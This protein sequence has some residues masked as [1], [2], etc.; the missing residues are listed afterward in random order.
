[1]TEL[2]TALLAAR[3][4]GVSATVLLAPG[5]LLLT[6]LRA[7]VEWTERV[8]LAFSLSYGWIFVLSIAVP[9]LGLNVDAAAV[10]TLGALAVLGIVAFKH[11]ARP[12]VARS[13]DRWD[14]LL[15]GLVLAAAVAA[16]IIEPSFTG[17]EALDLASISRFADGGA[18]SFSNTSLFPDTRPVYLFQPYQ[19]ALGVIG[20]WSGVDPLVALIKFRVILVPLALIFL[21]N[22]VRRLTDRRADAAAV[23]VV[24]LLFLGLDFPTWEMNSLFPLVRRGGVGAGLC[25]PAML[26]LCLAATRTVEDR[27][28]RRARQIA[29]CAAPV[30]L[31]ASLATHP[32]EMFTV[33][34]FA[35]GMTL[36]IATGLDRQ[37]DRRQAAMLLF[38]LIAAAGT[39][40]VLQTR[41]V[42]YVA[43]YEIDQKRPLRAELARLALNPIAA[44]AGQPLPAADLLT[45]TI[46]ATTAT[47]FGMIALPV[48][49]LRLPAT[50][51]MLAVGIVPLA[52][53]YATPAGF[54]LLTLLTSV[55]TVRD[56][57]AYFGLLGL[58][59]L[60]IALTAA[61]HAALDHAGRRP[62]GFRRVLTVAFGISLAASVVVLLGRPASRALAAAAIVRPVVVLTVGAA[63]ALATL[64]VAWRMRQPLVPASRFAVGV[65]VLTA[66]FAI[67]F[68]LPEAGLGGVFTRR[69]PIHVMRRIMT[70]R[71]A[72]SVLEWPAYYAQLQTT[73]APPL[74]VPRLVVDE[75]RRRIPPRQIVLADPRYSCALV[76]LIDAYCINPASIYGHYFQPAIA[77]FREYVQERGSD[78]PEHP[79]FNSTASLSDAERTL[80]Q[81]F[82]VQYVLTDPEFDDLMASK[83]TTVVDGITLET[84][85]GGYRLYRV[86]APAARAPAR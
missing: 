27:T 83:L 79:F 11:R 46:P 15:G 24:M 82:D 39:Y 81:R 84:D 62:A 20:R 56:V 2:E 73:I 66:C 19:L 86:T 75:L 22:L 33:L 32:L 28:S 16:W 64:V 48:A 6:V 4:V 63:A 54:I 38:L 12:S 43:E 42:P 61:A 13:P 50:A 37:G 55:E 74:P 57:N 17:E 36:V 34:Y 76:V 1:M 7:P 40:V 10:L 8:V 18:I 26:A 71:S 23:F 29:F 69:E 9:T 3:L 80:I 44:V 45:R 5:L 60:A 51:A 68:A 70:A 47:V 41:L 49:A 53:M 67:P 58:I 59:A 78:T 14:L 30:M 35:A 72:P 25:V 77:Y 31:V 21:F 85:V 52:L 65:A